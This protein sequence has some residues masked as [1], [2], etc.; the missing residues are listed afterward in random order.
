MLVLLKFLKF[1]FCFHIL[2]VSLGAMQL[3]LTSH[4]QLIAGMR[5]SSREGGVESIEN[6]ADWLDAAKTKSAKYFWDLDK[7]DDRENQLNP[8]MPKR[9]EIE[10]FL[11]EHLAESYQN[12]C[13]VLYFFG[14]SD[15]NYPDVFFPNMDTLIIVGAE[16]CGSFPDVNVYLE[17]G[18]LK[19]T[20]L[21]VGSII[22][23][24]PFRSFYIT[25]VL[26]QAKYSNTTTLL[27]VAIVLANYQ[28]VSYSSF[29]LDNQG[30]FHSENLDKYLP[31]IRITY[32]K[33]LLDKE[34][35]VFYF[36]YWL[37]SDALHEGMKNFIKKIDVDT[38]FYKATSFLTQRL[39]VPNNFV[40]NQVKY[41]VQEDAGIPFTS[42]DSND[43]DMHLFGVYSRPFYCVTLPQDWG[44]QLELLDA[45]RSLIYRSENALAIDRLEMIWGPISEV[46][47]T[48]FS[49]INTSWDDFVPFYFGYGGQLTH[50]STNAF[51]STL[52]Y[53][54]KKE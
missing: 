42:F 44:I 54:I 48:G 53:A 12:T 24:M 27:A 39:N 52:Q 28:I 45:Y 4:A 29:F 25:K 7:V 15:F 49:S 33:H 36:Q 31:G 6:N 22:D 47:I 35:E 51:T 14:A 38:A 37:T 2:F 26:K 3:S 11:K 21:E 19:K 46:Y 20:M 8:F 43:W 40:L 13:R 23:P 9:K 5:P 41:V 17:K 18:I 32:K 1:F 34:R 50:H 16:P 30:N 10:S